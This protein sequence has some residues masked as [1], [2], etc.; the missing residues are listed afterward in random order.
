M[1][2][3]TPQGATQASGSDFDHF[4]ISH[5]RTWGGMPAFRGL[6][7]TLNAGM[8]SVLASALALRARRQSGRARADDLPADDDARGEASQYPPNRAS[9]RPASGPTMIYLC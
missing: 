2:C 8:S 4:T 6:R 5:G 9:G 1:R 3:A 7:R